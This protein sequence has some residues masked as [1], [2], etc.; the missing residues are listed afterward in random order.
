MVRGLKP[1]CSLPTVIQ[2][3]TNLGSPGVSSRLLGLS[4][5]RGDP[6]YHAAYR[7]AAEGRRLPAPAPQPRGAPSFST[8]ILAAGVAADG[9]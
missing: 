7:L 2:V 1:Q 3:G 5:H 9:A 8:W 4:T 6:R